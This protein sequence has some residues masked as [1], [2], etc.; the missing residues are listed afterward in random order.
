[1]GAWDS[2]RSGSAGSPWLGV[3][4]PTSPVCPWGPPGRRRRSP[5]RF[6]ARQACCV[7]R[8]LGARRRLC[9]CPSPSRRGRGS[10]EPIAHGGAILGECL[11]SP[12]PAAGRH[13]PLPLRRPAVP[14]LAAVALDVLTAPRVGSPVLT[15]LIARRGWPFG[16]PGLRGTGLG[17]PAVG[18]VGPARCLVSPGGGHGH[19]V[20]GTGLLSAP[21]QP[22]PRAPPAAAALTGL[23]PG[24][25][26]RPTRAHTL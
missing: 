10:R 5:P 19:G 16:G 18:A 8:G 17:D 23:P 2:V 15:A 12:L 4:R 21:S 20:E 13:R 7:Q 6:P 3:R 24:G 1:M 26:L 9:S 11:P 14:V 25:S 22:G